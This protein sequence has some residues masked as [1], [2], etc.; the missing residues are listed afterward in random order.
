MV[1]GR[2]II[3]VDDN[4]KASTRDFSSLDKQVRKT[5][6]T[7]LKAER[8]FDKLGGAINLV[9]GAV[10]VRQVGKLGF[11]LL[12]AASDAEE[13]ASKFNTIFRD[14]SDGAN[15]V[16]DSFANSFGLANTKSKELLGNTAD[17][18]TGFGFTQKEALNLSKQVNELAVDLASFSNFAGG[19]EGAS[20]ALTKALLGETESAKS[21]GI[22]IRQNSKEYNAQIKA[23]MQS[24]GVTELQAK[25]YLN[26]EQAISQSSNAIGDFARTSESFA[27]QSR[28]ASQNL[29]DLK[30]NLGNIIIPSATAFLKELNWGL[31]QLNEQFRDK[32][33]IEVQQKAFRDLTDN[34][35]NT[36]SAIASIEKGSRFYQEIDGSVK[37]VSGTTEEY[38]QKLEVLLNQQ[39]NLKRV[40]QES[41]EVRSKSNEIQK[42]SAGIIEE[43]S[44]T[45]L[46]LKLAL[47]GATRSYADLKAA[48]ASPEELATAREEITATANA[49]LD[50]KDALDKVNDKIK[51]SR[52]SQDDLAF[53]W[54]NAKKLIKEASPQ[55]ASSFTDAF[56]RPLKQGENALDRFRNLF[57]DVVSDITQQMAKNA[58][59]SSIMDATKD[60]SAG[61]LGAA[62]FSAVGGEA[63]NG[64][65]AR[66][67]GIEHFAGGGVIGGMTGATKGK[68]NTIAAVRTGEMI[69]NASQQKNLF[70][71]ANNGGGGGSTVNVINNS[72]SDIQTVT[73]PNNEVDIFVNQV[74]SA[75]SSSRTNSGFESANSRASSTGL[76]A[77]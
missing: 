44:K 48:G 21:L 22:V 10:V 6:T 28:I 39:T 62:I 4:A 55:I 69:L 63:E 7:A 43:Q 45:Y 60:S 67:G 33:G 68:D 41:L 65:V 73:R 2:V 5:G 32:T 64:G 42:E 27:N 51:E 35:I 76:Q 24:R 8:S 14:I 23:L 72:Q 40:I 58:L 31:E 61:S 26:L 53:S 19:T 66:N 46:D 30:E 71:M 16:A 13:T 29:I 20:E 52:E 54:E 36:E 74:N 75:L 77:V 70:D 15:E 18:L 12:N 1:D 59:I 50:V 34:I 17:L 9:A 56:V 49:Y 25:A 37:K 47:D 38:S 57:A 3:K 11:S